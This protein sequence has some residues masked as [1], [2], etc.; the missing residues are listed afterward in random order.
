M[1]DSLVKELLADQNQVSMCNM[2]EGGKTM[3]FIDVSEVISI[4]LILDVGK[5]VDNGTLKHIVDNMGNIA[6]S[7]GKQI[8]DASGGIIYKGDSML[9]ESQIVMSV[10]DIDISVLSSVISDV[11]DLDGVN[12]IVESIVTS[13]VNETM[14][15]TRRKYVGQGD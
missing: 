14:A 4:Y 2:I 15:R 10:K 11:E 5:E 12:G 3:S 7:H 6:E 8:E 1:K 9:M 13:N